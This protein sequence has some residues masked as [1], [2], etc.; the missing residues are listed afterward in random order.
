MKKLIGSLCAV[1]AVGLTPAARAEEAAKAEAKT[2]HHMTPPKP[3][4]EL[5]KMKWTIGAWHC[6]G[7]R[8]MPPEA[9]GGTVDTKATMTIKAALDNW[10]YSG[11]F[12]AEKTKEMP[13]MKAQ[14][15]WGYN[16]VDKH[17]VQVWMDSMGGMSHSTSN[18][19]EGDKE[20]WEG[21][22]VMMG[23]KMKTR[24]T[25]TKKSDKEIALA[26]EVEAEAGK[27]VAMGE[28]SCKK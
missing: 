16:P 2:E 10:Y 11:D 17:Y 12:K 4:P 28:D 25:L 26:D 8:H 20:V 27:W 14:V 18:G 13:G 7:K 15:F 1:F 9:G 3:G 5:E 24:S 19:L 22:A 21:E 6:T 23:K